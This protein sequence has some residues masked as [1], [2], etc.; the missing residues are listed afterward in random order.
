M[1]VHALLAH[2]NELGYQLD[3]L[4]AGPVLRPVL[5]GAVMPRHTLAMLK[6]RKAWL[7]AYLSSCPDCGRDCRLGE[8]R[9]RVRTAFNPF[10]GNSS[11]PFRHGG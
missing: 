8:D 6:E 9:E 5:K 2:L 10:C 1:T 7:V 4:D 3:I 11:C